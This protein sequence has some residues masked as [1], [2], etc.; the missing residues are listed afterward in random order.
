MSRNQNRG[1]NCRK[2]II[3]YECSRRPTK[4]KSFHGFSDRNK[5]TTTMAPTMT[6]G[7]WLMKTCNFLLTRNNYQFCDS[8]LVYP[9][10]T[11]PRCWLE[12]HWIELNKIIGRHYWKRNKP[13]NKQDIILSA[14]EQ[15]ITFCVGLCPG[16]CGGE[17][18]RESER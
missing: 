12:T 5:Q 16:R 18:E 10:S 4:R 7:T 3:V 17:R 14:K 15:Q 6:R 13:A 2:E 11:N 9:P 8:W 1:K